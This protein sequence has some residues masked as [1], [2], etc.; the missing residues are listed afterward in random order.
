[1]IMRQ[2]PVES[3]SSV[4]GGE[5]MHHSL[6]GP[7]RSMNLKL[8]QRCNSAFKI[9]D[10]L[11][12]WV[13]RHAAWP[14]HLQKDGQGHTPDW[15]LYGT[16]Y[17]HA[18]CKLGEQVLI[19]LP[20]DHHRTGKFTPQWVKG[21]SRG[22]TDSSDEHCVQTVRGTIVSRCTHGQDV[23]IRWL[24][25][26]LS[27]VYE[28]PWESQFGAKTRQAL[29]DEPAVPLALRAATKTPESE[30]APLTALGGTA[31]P[32]AGTPPRDIDPADVPTPYTPTLTHEPRG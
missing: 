9:T 25:Q 11:I 4:G 15:K 22:K 28:V 20:E 8:E 26:L 23:G 10:Q 3:H 1:M 5:A 2:S 13:C 12:P 30:H 29:E 6:E 16:A 21:V 32:Q 24:L 31:K 17:T 14:R 19:I 7:I 18:M 27:E